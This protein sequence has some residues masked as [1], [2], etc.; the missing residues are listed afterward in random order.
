MENNEK[1]IHQTEAKISTSANT[2]QF[3]LN[4]SEVSYAATSHI[5]FAHN[6]KIDIGEWTNSGQYLSLTLWGVHPENLKDLGNAFLQI[7]EKL[8]QRQAKIEE[9]AAIIKS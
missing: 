1:L 2:T 7:A 8:E 5:G 9:A 4:L 3:T 6:L